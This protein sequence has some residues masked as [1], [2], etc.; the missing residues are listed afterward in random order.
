MVGGKLTK[1][2]KSAVNVISSAVDA[3]DVESEKKSKGRYILLDMD[4]F[5]GLEDVRQYFQGLPAATGT[6]ASPSSYQ[7]QHQSTANTLLNN[8]NNNNNVPPDQNHDRSVA[9]NSVSYWPPQHDIQTGGAHA[10][11]YDVYKTYNSQQ[12]PSSVQNSNYQQQKSILQETVKEQQHKATHNLPPIAAL[13]NYHTGRSREAI[14]AP[15]TKPKSII[16]TTAT[17]SSGSIA[18]HPNLKQYNVPQQ[19]R[20]PLQNPVENYR[21]VGHNQYSIPNQYHNSSYYS[22]AAPTSVNNAYT[23]SYPQQQSQSQQSQ[24]QQQQQQQSSS[25]TH[26]TH[27]HHH[28]H[29]VLTKTTNHE[30]HPQQNQYQQ[31][32]ATSSS[33]VDSV[34][35]LSLKTIKTPADSTLDDAEDHQRNGKY[36][37]I[38]AQANAPR[39]SEPYVAQAANQ[40][41]H[42]NMQQI[43]QQMPQPQSTGAP[44]V[45]FLPN[46]NM[47]M[48]QN[49]KPTDRRHNLNSYQ[50]HQIQRQPH[51]I[52][53]PQP[54]PQQQQQQQHY[55]T[56][57]IM[58]NAYNIAN[59]NNNNKKTIEGGLPRID[60]PSSNQI[61]K[62]GLYQNL[63][64]HSEAHRKRSAQP[65]ATVVQ[66]KR[67]KMDDRWKQVIDKQIEQKFSSYQSAKPTTLPSTKD[68]IVNGNFISTN[69]N[70]NATYQQINQYQTM[71]PHQYSN[72]N[73]YHQM[74]QTYV[75][76]V[77]AHHYPS[78][79]AHTQQ[80]QNQ[81]HPQNIY[82]QN[83]ARTNSQT[84]L[85]N[86]PQPQPNGGGGGGGADKRVI[87]IL[88]S[89]LEMKGA[90]E[91][92]KKMEQSH[93]FKSYDFN[94]RPREV[95]HPST[96]V[97]APLQPKHGFIGR[98]NVSPF[99]AASLIE[100]STPPTYKFP[101]AI[102]SVRFEADIKEEKPSEQSS[103]TN[104]TDLDGLAANLAARIRTKGELKQVAQTQHITNYV[105]HNSPNL[106]E[107][108][109]NGASNSSPPKDKIVYPPR[110]R[111]F[112][113]NEED[114][115]EHKANVPPRDKTGLRSSSETSVFDFP[116][117]GDESE[118]PVSERQSLEDMRRDRKSISKQSLVN[119]SDFKEER[120]ESPIDDIFNQA[121][122]NFLEQLMKGGGKKRGRRKK[123][124][125]DVLAK[126]E[127]VTKEKPLNDD[128]LV[129][130]EVKDLN[131]ETK[132]VKMEEESDS[133]LPLIQCKQDGAQ[134][135]PPKQEEQEE[136]IIPPVIESDSDCDCEI[137][138]KINMKEIIDKTKQL[139]AIVDLTATITKPPKKP[140]F[141]DGSDFYPGWEEECFKYKKS[142]RMP[143][144]LIQFT[145]PP[146]CNRLSTS[147]PD[148]DPCPS[149]TPSSVTD[150]S[151]YCKFKTKTKSENF[152]S[153]MDSNSCFNFSMTKNYDSE[154]GSSSVKSL[155]VSNKITDRLLERYGGK[156]RKR[157]K[158]KE[159]KESPKIIPKSDNTLELLPTPS[160]EIKN[161]SK[162]KS[163]PVVKTE[164]VFFGFR[165]KT[166]ESFKDT[167]IKNTKNL[168]G[169]GEQFTTVVLKS[170]TRTEA[171]VL[172]QKATI[173]EVF[174]EDR[175]AS[176]PPVTCVDELKE[177]SEIKKEIEPPSTK[178][179]LK[180]KLLNRGKKTKEASKKIITTTTTTPEKLEES[181]KEVE[182][183]IEPEIKSETPSIDGEETNSIKKR[184]K[185]RNI[186]RKGS[187]GFDYIRK[188]KKQ[189]KKDLGDPNDPTIKNKRR[190]A[191]P[192][193]NL[194][195][196]QDIQKEIKMWVLNKGIGETHLHRS[197]RLGYTDIT[198]YCL[199]K[200]QGS[201]SPKDNAGYT[202]LHE[203]CSRGHLAIAKL[204]LMYGA[205]ASESAQGGIRPLHE[206]A[207]N[208]Y[209]EIVRLLLSYGAD[210][211][212][213]TYSGSTPLSLAVEES[214]LNLLRNHINDIQG[215][216]SD[217]WRFYGP[218]ACFDLEES[219]YDPLES[220]PAPDP[221][222]EDE[223]IDFEVS[224]TLLPNL[225][226]LAGEP[227]T[228]RW[229]LL[230]DLSNLLKI[231]SKDAL[232]R[233]INPPSPSSTSSS[234]TSAA[235]MKSILRELKMADFLE[236]ARCCQFLNAGEKVNSRS[237]KVALVKY[238]D[239]VRQLLNVEKVLITAR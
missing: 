19:A 75:P 122:D 188:K 123:M 100:R 150:A 52:S 120:N 231:K 108:S 107:T 162:K 208:G 31:N 42:R 94:Q 134:P 29:Q 16:A 63:Q 202:P 35:D 109:F 179:M 114:N 92:Q 154:E 164:S 87:S 83:L 124:E 204:L 219:G 132:L 99:T 46:F 91:A 126:L 111:L 159:E 96:D 222:I 163:E 166:V 201:P 39:Y 228:D 58:N 3:I 215:L 66:N 37:Q 143:R 115:G 104:Q 86:R 125:P 239:K 209:V 13:S 65:L 84:N 15:I 48:T 145:R 85:N 226:T 199:E 148:L 24:S 8:N 121:C 23:T 2:P 181:E 207:E 139:R 93:Q 140:I 55:N 12:Q 45:D 56:T 67:P 61:Q 227:Q 234:T 64:Q 177:K 196:V 69:D 112:S 167:F 88:R 176:A 41:P 172:K 53:Q 238:T 25:V 216:P 9:N 136:E 205:N 224:E 22:A 128:N 170:R 217:P 38:R 81:Q 5:N 106:S 184:N 203:A 17:T 59:N 195:S 190:S 233:Q 57:Q 186:R 26:S 47:P 71:Q 146:N 130:I 51:I 119:E 117:S 18:Q 28:H 171:R 232:L 194:E 220:P 105:R 50:Q 89:N 165:K 138:T 110:R 70:K 102:D 214:T 223:D 198:A 10:Y 180:N 79:I 62:S 221:P 153:D 178:E 11:N 151:D 156:K 175:P 169:V 4:V 68:L 20:V 21:N 32:S 60:F 127:T 40:T 185:F 131:P 30:I 144:G 72:T 189:V 141:G 206:A 6:T 157:L 133:D 101:K 229:V 116:D 98:Q 82:Q 113:R 210:P 197:A 33:T 7:H 225:Y 237:S 213:A 14:R 235:N 43:R 182:I 230:Q 80:I 36:Y 118:V 78:H 147:L 74:N 73:Q 174:G 155:N 183:K 173:R 44:K 161:E 218:A 192:K 49:Y 142:L 168:V 160:L 187:S 191:L 97:T 236:Q 1:Q 54:Q 149:P 135:E 212:L 34:L 76:S 27:H 77:T 193:A 137:Q 129:K 200:M 103:L 158:K 152:D 90:K 211:N 95:Q